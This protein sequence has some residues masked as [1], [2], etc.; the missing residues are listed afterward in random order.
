MLTLFT[1]PKPFKG[2]AAVAQD[3]A[4]E[5]WRRIDPA[6][7]IILFGDEEGIARAAARHGVE[8][9]A[10]VRRNAQGTPLLDHAFATAQAG[11][12]HRLVGYVN[13]DIIFLPDFASALAEVRLA[14]FLLVGR[15]VDLDV[16][17]AID[18]RDGSW[19]R[20]LAGRAHRDGRLHEATGIDYFVFPRHQL[21][22][23][24][25]FPVGRALWDNWMI[26]HARSSGIPVIDATPRVTVV[27]QNHDYGH[28]RGGQRAVEA[29]VEVQRNWEIVGPD[30]LQLTIDDATWIM[31]PAGP[32]PARDPRH[33]LRRVAVWPALSPRM[34]SS[35]RVVRRVFHALQSLRR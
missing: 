30:F 8:H 20:T 12:R 4:I 33:L 2:S 7:Q 25:P 17:E 22:R 13:A 32:M 21:T 35:V 1:I 16:P 29:G 23:I 9:V 15:R 26:H 3:N 6:V 5:S 11:A 28:V 31:G 27:H 34:R 10:D 18:F 19:S 24:P 14:R